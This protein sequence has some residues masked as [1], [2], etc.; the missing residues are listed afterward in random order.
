[1]RR[2]HSEDPDAVEPVAGRDTRRSP[3]AW[4]P[5]L[6][7]NVLLFFADSGIS[8]YGGGPCGPGYTGGGPVGDE[9]CCGLATNKECCHPD[10]GDKALF[11]CPS[12]YNKTWW[13]C[14]EGTQAYGCG[15]CAQGDNCFAGPWECSIIWQVV[16]C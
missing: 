14:T 16:P 11:K 8:S 10:S 13:F 12:G 7:M 3:F 6:G 2:N 9:K 15:E 1:M 4:I 5:R